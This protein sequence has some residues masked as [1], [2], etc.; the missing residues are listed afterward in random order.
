MDKMTSP[1]H[2][3]LV[4]AS[5]DGAICNITLNRESKYNA[6]N[7]QMINELCLLF[8]WTATRSAGYT[9]ELTDPDGKPYLRVIVLSGT[10]KH[11]CA[12]ADINMMRDA[13]ANSPEDNRRDSER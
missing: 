3:E 12:G 5:I 10:G 1:P 6:M 2:T 4:S 13:G 7:V 11:F 9:G 8:E